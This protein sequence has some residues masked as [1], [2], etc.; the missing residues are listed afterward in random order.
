MAGLPSLRLVD[1]PGKTYP[2]TAEEEQI[3]VILDGEDTGDVFSV[4]I[5]DNGDVTIGPPGGERKSNKSDKFDANLAD[6]IDDGVLGQIGE[7]LL[8]GIQA[9]ETSRRDWMQLRAKGIEMLGLEIKAA[10]TGGSAEGA[11]LEGMSQ[12][13]HPGLLEAVIQ[14]QSN[15]R[16]ELLPTDGP[17]KI[18]IDDPN[19]S[20][21]MNPLADDLEQAM[22]VYLTVTD[23]SYYEDTD[24]LLFRLGFAGS[25]FKKVYHHPLKRRPVAESVGADNLIVSNT[26]TDLDSAA[27]VTHRIPDMKRSTMKRMMLAGAYREIELTAPDQITTDT[28]VEQKQEEAGLVTPKTKRPEDLTYEVLECY[29]ELDIPGYEHKERGKATG[30]P[31]P[32]KVTIERSS[33]KVLEV[34]RN[35]HEGDETY[36]AKRTFVHYILVPGFGFYGLGFLHILGQINVAITA[37]WREMLDAGMFANFPGFLYAAGGARQK[38]NVFRVPPG[39][40]QP[41]E[42]NGMP[43]NDAIM[44]LPYKEPGPAMIQFIQHI[45][46]VGARL[47]GTANIEVGEGKQDAP[48][49]TTMALIE[50]ATKPLVAIHKRLYAAQAREFQLLRDLLRE[51]PKALFTNTR[52]LRRT[53]DEATILKALNDYDL[54]PQADPNTASHM[55][56]LMKAVALKQLQ[57]QSPDL[58]DAKAVDTLVLRMTNVA[59]PEE[60]FAKNPQPAPDPKLIEAEAKMKLAEAGVAEKQANVQ[61]KQ[62]DIQ[63]KGQKAQAD[64][65]IG[66]AKV[67]G[68]QAKSGLAQVRMQGEAQKHQIEGARLQL[69]AAGLEETKRQHDNEMML[70]QADLAGKHA[71]QKEAQD[72]EDDRERIAMEL[73]RADVEKDFALAEHKETQANRREAAKLETQK[74]VADD[75]NKTSLEIARIGAKAKA[76]TAAQTTNRK[77]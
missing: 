60:V 21:E 8:E 68:E 38:T 12:I 44:P 11:P 3:D 28:A 62:V 31:L 15:A 39:G 73:G 20:I 67:Q 50:Q 43:I 72:N 63:A 55:Q 74:E 41:V 56:R 5:A 70:A 29:T 40:G 32:Y 34:R 49:G 64:L 61:L 77:K 76:K 7:E 37:A 14:F 36:T 47:G 42:T 24:K 45:E 19:Q 75:N 35:W 33:R 2:D 4:H 48:V 66:L 65:Q 46:E 59:K 58:Y 13:R 69:E 54:T 25:E 23:T 1:T 22:N 6:E 57:A 30:L 26:A 53:W 16:S 17:V 52:G 51:D 10:A 27:R 18:R 9:D 71:L